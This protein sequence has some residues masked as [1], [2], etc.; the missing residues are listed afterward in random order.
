MPI[1]MGKTSAANKSE[2]IPYKHIVG[3]NKR[4]INTY[5]SASYYI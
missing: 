2:G 4:N 3:L 5:Y 1:N